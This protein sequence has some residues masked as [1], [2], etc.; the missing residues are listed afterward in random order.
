MY[1]LIGICISIVFSFLFACAY[2]VVAI[3]RQ[4]HP[5]AAFG[6]TAIALCG[7]LLHIAIAKLNGWDVIFPGNGKG[8]LLVVYYMDVFFWAS[9]LWYLV[10]RRFP[11]QARKILDAAFGTAFGSK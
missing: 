11:A 5:K 2:V 8:M 4:G 10:M 7:A 3:S 9:I 1:V 6:I